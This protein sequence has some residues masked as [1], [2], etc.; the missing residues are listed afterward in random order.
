LSELK[1][2]QVQIAEN[3]RSLNDTHRVM[4][5]SNIKMENELISMRDILLRMLYTLVGVLSI[6]VVGDKVFG[7]TI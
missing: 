6:L 5:Q 7:M 2:T 1:T 3:L 4:C